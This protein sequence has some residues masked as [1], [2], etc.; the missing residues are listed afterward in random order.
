M[1][2]CVFVTVVGPARLHAHG[3]SG[4][5][6]LVVKVVKIA[7][8]WYTRPLC[9]QTMYY[10]MYQNLTKGIRFSVCGNIPKVQF[11][12]PRKPVP[13]SAPY[14]VGE[15]VEYECMPGFELQQA[16]KSHITCQEDGSWSE[17]PLCIYKP[18]K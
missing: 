15:L 8:I 12:E 18:S 7:N 11:G 2:A 3:V 17:S 6:S 14:F 13:H 9:Y 16:K 10:Y 1:S 4:H 5:I